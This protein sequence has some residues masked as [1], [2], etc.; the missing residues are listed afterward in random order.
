MGK[1]EYHMLLGMEISRSMQ[2]PA[3]EKWGVCE[4]QGI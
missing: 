2:H 1:V 4:L 3:W